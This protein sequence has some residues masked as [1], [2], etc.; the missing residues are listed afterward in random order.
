MSVF[1][2]VK[3]QAKSEAAA[4]AHQAQLKITTQRSPE[5][6]TLVQGER[7]KARK[8][9]STAMKGAAC[10]SGQ[11]DTYRKQVTRYCPESRR[12]KPSRSVGG[13]VPSKAEAAPQVSMKRKARGGQRLTLRAK[14]RF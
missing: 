13:W 6:L 8:E 5:R 12:P 11:L 4:E 2:K 14:Q 10:L 9:A 1:L 3:V 7:A